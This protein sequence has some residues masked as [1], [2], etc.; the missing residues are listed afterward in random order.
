MTLHFCKMPDGKRIMCICVHGVDHGQA[1]LDV[2]LAGA[3]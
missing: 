1:E 2:P 3:K